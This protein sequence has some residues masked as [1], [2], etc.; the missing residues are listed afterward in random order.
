[1]EGGDDFEVDYILWIRV[2]VLTAPLAQDIE[3]NK[4]VNKYEQGGS[5]RIDSHNCPPQHAG[6]RG[7][8]P[9]LVVLM[10]GGHIQGPK[11]LG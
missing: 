8:W 11:G 2:K 1:M 6:F 4:T 9:L 7:D 3:K 10:L 5:T